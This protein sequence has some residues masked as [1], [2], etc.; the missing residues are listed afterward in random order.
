ML[1]MVSLIRESY[2]E[3]LVKVV[4]GMYMCDYQKDEVYALFNRYNTWQLRSIVEEM[5]SNGVHSILKYL[6]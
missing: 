5:K 3:K 6:D 4:M 1:I 2:L